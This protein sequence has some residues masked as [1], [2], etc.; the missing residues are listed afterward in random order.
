MKP[1][2]IGLIY[3]THSDELY[4]MGEA[5]HG[6]KAPHEAGMQL[7]YHERVVGPWDP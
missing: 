1:L 3:D 5:G 2:R 4:V 6:L 7:V